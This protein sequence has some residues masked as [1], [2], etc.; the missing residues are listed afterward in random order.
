M[1]CALQVTT[2]SI[3]GASRRQPGSG[4][5]RAVA[6]NEVVHVPFQSA[7]SSL[8]QKT[9]EPRVFAA[10]IAMQEEA[11]RERLRALFGPDISTITTSRL[12]VTGRLQRRRKAQF[13][14]ATRLQRS[15]GIL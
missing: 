4:A 9:L 7:V 10:M 11:V 13:G 1:F 8:L 5:E 12:S 3:G 2:P 6:M 15:W 14:R